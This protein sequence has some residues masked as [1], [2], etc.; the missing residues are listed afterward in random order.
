[1][2]APALKRLRE[3]K[4]N[5]T[6][7]DLPL[8]EQWPFRFHDNRRLSVTIL[9]AAGVDIRTAADRHGQS[10]AIIILDRYAHGLPERDREAAGLLGIALGGAIATQAARPSKR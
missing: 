5:A 9:I 2:E 7:K 3:T 6:Q 1:M 10:R 4:P 8:A